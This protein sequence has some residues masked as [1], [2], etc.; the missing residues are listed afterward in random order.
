M[1]VVVFGEAAK[2]LRRKK[3]AR[4]DEERQAPDTRGDHYAASKERGAEV[5]VEYANL[6]RLVVCDCGHRRPP[7]MRSARTRADIMVLPPQASQ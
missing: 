6:A 2:G 7:Q 1:R 4:V 3:H 5:V